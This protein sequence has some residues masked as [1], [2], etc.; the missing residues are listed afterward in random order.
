M[1]SELGHNLQLDLSAQRPAAWAGRH[2]CDEQVCVETWEQRKSRV[3]DSVW[4]EA[5]LEMVRQ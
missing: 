3:V 1:M 4:R 2:H 5:E